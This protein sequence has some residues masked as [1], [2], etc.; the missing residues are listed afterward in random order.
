MSWAGKETS[1]HG[2][3]VF[4]GDTGRMQYKPAAGGYD[5]YIV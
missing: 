1:I 4:S 5:L 3:T 2:T